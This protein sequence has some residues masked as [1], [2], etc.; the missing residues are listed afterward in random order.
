[1]EAQ[2]LKSHMEAIYCRCI[3]IL[4]DH[5]QAEDVLQ[6]VMTRYFEAIQEREIHKPLHYLYRASTN[7]CLVVLQKRKRALPF[8]SSLLE[9]LG[10]SHRNH[11]EATRSIVQMQEHFGKEALQLMVYRHLDQ[12]TYQEIAEI[13]GISDRGVK[14]RLDRLEEKVRRYFQR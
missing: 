1:M 10:L 6:E 7:H 8:E 14:K 5:E 2:Q 12:M 11:G 9:T 4:R 13:Y 3:R